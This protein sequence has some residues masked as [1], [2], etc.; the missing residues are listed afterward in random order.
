MKK[1]F[2]QIGIV[3]L[4]ATMFTACDKDD[5]PAPPSTQLRPTVDYASLTATSNYFETFKDSAGATTVNFDGQTT[6]QDMLAELN[7]LMSSGSKGTIVDSA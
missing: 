5:N 2:S 3:A 1:I 4:T 6:R 7:S